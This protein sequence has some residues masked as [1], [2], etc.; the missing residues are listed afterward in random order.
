MDPGSGRLAAAGALPTPLSDLT[1][2]GLPGRI[3]LVGGRSSGGTVATITSL[4]PA[5]AASRASAPHAASSPFAPTPPGDVYA[6]D[7]PGD[8]SPAV[9]GAP[10]R[11]YVPNSESDTVDVIDPRTYRVIDHFAVGGLPQHVVPS[12]DLKTLYVTND[13]GNSL[14]PIDPRSGRPGTPIAVDDPYNLYFTPDGRFAIVVA[15]RNA[16]LDFRDPHT[17][18]LRHRLP[19]PCRGVDHMD[20]SADGTYLIASCEFSGQVVKVDL[21]HQRVVGVLTLGGSS[22][23]PQDVKLSPDGSLFYVADMMAGGVWKV[24]G[25]RLRTDRI[26][27]HRE[28]RPRPL[29]EPRRELPL[30]LEPRCRD[31]L[32]GVLRHRTGHPDVDDPRRGQPRHGRRLA[33]RSGALAERALQRRRLRDRHR[34]TAVCSRRSP[35]GAARTAWPSGRSRGG[36]RSATRGSSDERQGIR[37]V[38]CV[39]AGRRAPRKKMPGRPG[40]LEAEARV[41]PQRRGRQRR[42]AGAVVADEEDR[43][44]RPRARRCPRIDGVAQGQ[45]EAVAVEVDGPAAAAARACPGGPGWRRGRWRG[46]R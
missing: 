27:P 22:D 38:P 16:R 26:P 15:E 21:V 7:M 5:P 18:E 44:A 35:S 13:T 24:D 30:R 31:H 37:R 17:M 42:R 1:A 36:T 43:A 4:A 46:C 6:H 2:A 34:A 41:V 45:R 14:T 11:I 9:A 39:S 28:G 10:N 25:A 8:M 23:M 33:R 19:V 40:G 3:L 29:P 20:F 32:R 12:W